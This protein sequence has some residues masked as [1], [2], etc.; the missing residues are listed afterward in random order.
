MDGSRTQAAIHKQTAINK[1][2]LSTLVKQLNQ[3]KLLTGDPKT[4][5]LAITIPPNFFDQT[6]GTHG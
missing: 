1:G 3:S 5:K 2:Q 4:P 6:G